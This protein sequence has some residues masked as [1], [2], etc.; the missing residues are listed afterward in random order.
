M[1]NDIVRKYVMKQKKDGDF[2]H[3]SGYARTQSG[4]GVGAAGGATKKRF[5]TEKRQF[6]QGYDDSSIMRGVVKRPGEKAQVYT[7]PPKEMPT[8]P[9]RPPLPPKR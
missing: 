4:D 1:A 6:V 9:A 3:S 7:P 8:T 2:L 5:E